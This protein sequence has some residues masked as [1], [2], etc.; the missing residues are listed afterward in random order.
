MRRFRRDPIDEDFSEMTP[1][2]FAYEYKNARENQKDAYDIFLNVQSEE[3]KKEFDESLADP[4][5][6]ENAEDIYNSE[7]GDWLWKR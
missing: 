4:S 3:Y 2:Q 6:G 7:G 1:R 5:L